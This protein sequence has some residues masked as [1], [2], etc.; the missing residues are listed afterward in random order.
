MLAAL[1]DDMAHLYNLALESRHAW[2]WFMQ[3]V[4]PRET[5]AYDWSGSSRAEEEALFDPTE[6]T[7]SYSSSAEEAM[8]PLLEEDS[9]LWDVCHAA[10]KQVFFTLPVDAGG[11]VRFPE[12]EFD[13]DPARLEEFVVR[14]TEEAFRHSPLFR[15]YAPRHAPSESQMCA[16]PPFEG[17]APGSVPYDNF[18]QAGQ[19]LLRG[20][21]LPSGRAAH[22]QMFRVGAE[23]CLCGW[24][25]R[26]DRCFPPTQGNTLKLVCD[27]LGTCLPDGSFPVE[28][29]ARALADFSL[30]WHCPETEL[31]AHWGYLDPSANEHWL[32]T[33][34][35]SNLH[36]SARD[37]FRHGRSGLRPGNLQTLPDLAKQYVSPATREVP[38]ERGRLTTCDPPPLDEDLLVRPFL[39]QLFPAAQ[40][41]EEAGALAY[42]LR[43]AIE[44]ARRQVLRLLLPD[45]PELEARLAAQAEVAERWR[46]R[47]G[48]Q[49]HLLHVCVSLGAFRPLFD[50]DS[51][52]PVAC[53]HFR[54]S[55][56]PPGRV[57]YVTPACL[58]SVDG[59]FYDP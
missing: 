8:S 37:L 5:Q 10:L 24:P 48:T 12:G 55:E 33:N 40:A 30:D 2:N 21:D 19:T 53:P 26:G 27:L 25:R 3:D 50:T 6:A 7:T 9:T 35:T 34:R 47:C 29:G 16:Q 38:L 59:V 51:R 28:D 1:Q 17:P 52:A 36:T 14:F 18:V 41:V 54:V 49:L 13:G 56:V 15:H 4:A 31:S 58:V 44:L 22:P 11:T 46:K 32:G 42:C 57:V 23:G 43:Y 45:H 20:Q 39:D